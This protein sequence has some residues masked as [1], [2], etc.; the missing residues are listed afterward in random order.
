MF[1]KM[2]KWQKQ[3]VHR[4]VSEC[5]SHPIKQISFQDFVLL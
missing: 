1:E 4:N 5:C 3:I 2:T